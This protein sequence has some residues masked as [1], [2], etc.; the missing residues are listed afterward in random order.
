MAA[1]MSAV[2]CFGTLG[3]IEELYGPYLSTLSA[4]VEL[5]SARGSVRRFVRR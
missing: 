4:Q 2:V 5:F 3:L 1:P